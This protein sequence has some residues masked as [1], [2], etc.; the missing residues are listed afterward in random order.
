MCAIC[1][2][3]SF[4][5]L[6]ISNDIKYWVFFFIEYKQLRS[7]HCIK[8]FKKLEYAS[9]EIYNWLADIL[10][11]VDI[12]LITMFFK[13]VIYDR[14]VWSILVFKWK[15]NISLFSLEIKKHKR[16]CLQEK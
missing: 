15:E 1:T 8:F 5:L 4:F 14:F 10:Y 11:I 13:H 6:L 7:S 3:T 16:H 2:I 12:F 9:C